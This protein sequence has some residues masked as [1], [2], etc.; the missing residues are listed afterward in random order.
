[1]LKINS[2]HSKKCNRWKFHLLVTVII[3]LYIS[4]LHNNDFHNVYN[5]ETRNSFYNVQLDSVECYIHW[6]YI[7]TVFEETCIN[8][9]LSRLCF[10]W[11]NANW[12]YF[13]FPNTL[14]GM[15]TLDHRIFHTTPYRNTTWT[16]FETSR[17]GNK[18]NKTHQFDSTRFRP[19][20]MLSSQTN[21]YSF[22]WKYILILYYSLYLSTKTT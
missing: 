8:Y 18:G 14:N 2:Y 16:N 17:V 15:S 4:Y 1:M 12:F 7:P 21:H 10:C 13:V 9:Q 3:I 19:A 5:P 11:M 20:I 6:F 22:L